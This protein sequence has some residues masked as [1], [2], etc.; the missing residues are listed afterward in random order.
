[1]DK[2]HISFSHFGVYGIVVNNKNEVLVVHKA[3][4]PYQG[5]YDLPGGGME[6]DELLL[7][8]LEREF[9]EEVG[10]AI[11]A[12]WQLRSFDNL[13]ECDYWI[14]PK[15][16]RKCWFRH[17]GVIYQV[18][19]A[20]GEIKQ[21]PDGNDSLGCAWIPLQDITQQN[22]SSFLYLAVALYEAIEL[23]KKEGKNISNFLLK[24][25]AFSN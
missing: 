25:K 8:T 19:I 4:G 22:S 2:N 9:L 21:S 13:V 3:K 18:E 7:E 6:P 20:E 10:L 15:E 5:L 23:A 12:C 17:V 16:T 11:T 1:M 14:D 24:E